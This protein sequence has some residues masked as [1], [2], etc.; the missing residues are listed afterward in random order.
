MWLRLAKD[1]RKIEV[2]WQVNDPLV[3]GRGSDY[4]P[5]VY[6]PPLLKAD[7]DGNPTKYYPAETVG[8]V[9]RWMNFYEPGTATLSHNAPQEFSSLPAGGYFYKAGYKL[10]VNA[11]LKNWKTLAWKDNDNYELKDPAVRGHL[12]WRFPDG[13]YVKQWGGINDIGLLGQVHR[14]TPWQTLYLKWRDTFSANRDTW[15]QWSGSTDTVPVND[16]RLIEVLRADQGRNN[17]GRFSVNNSEEN[18]WSA[19]FNGLAIPTHDPT[20]SQRLLG[21]WVSTATD[22]RVDAIG[23]MRWKSIVSAINGFRV[24]NSDINGTKGFVRKSDILGVQQL[25]GQSPYLKDV[26]TYDGVPGLD[27]PAYHAS[28]Y[29]D[30]LDVERIPQQIM[31]QLQVGGRQ[32]YQ[33]YIFTQSLR[34]ARSLFLPGTQPIPG[35]EVGGQNQGP[36]YNYEVSGQTAQRRVYEM[37]GAGQWHESAKR[38]H[39]GKFRNSAGILQDLAP[40]SPKVISENEISLSR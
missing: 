35:V 27:W 36:V 15:E 39:Y 34:P 12:D 32:F 18:K 22:Q 37:E 30:E 23:D 40:M 20:R 4:Q 29:A 10:G 7:T 13:L 2:S 31:S 16:R 26:T 9:K 24:L 17:Y 25:T 19:V 33:V 14:G 6:G 38:G 1:L 3:N 21:S 28:P 5:L 8:T 11:G